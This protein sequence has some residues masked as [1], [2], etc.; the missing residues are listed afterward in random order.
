MLLHLHKQLS[1]SSCVLRTE[2]SGKLARVSL[3][4][5]PLYIVNSTAGC[6]GVGAV[7]AVVHFPNAVINFILHLGGAGKQ[8]HQLTSTG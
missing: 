2:G 4:H 8:L 7:V 5:L 1:N 3:S 6:V